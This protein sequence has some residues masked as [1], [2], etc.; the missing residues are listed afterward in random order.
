MDVL[1]FDPFGPPFLDDPYPQFAE[2]LRRHPVFYAE[3]LG[4]WV[5]SGTTTVAACC[6]T[7]PR[8]RRATPSLR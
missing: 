6:A 1:D 8:S 2:H 7:T 3:D 5:V 4:Y